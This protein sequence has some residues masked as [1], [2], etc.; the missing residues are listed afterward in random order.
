[1]MPNIC[2]LVFAHI[3]HIG[4]TFGTPT[5]S[6]NNFMVIVE[7]WS[8]ITNK[9]RDFRKSKLALNGGFELN[10]I[11]LSGTILEGK[12]TTHISRWPVYFIKS[13]KLIWSV[14]MVLTWKR[15]LKKRGW[16]FTYILLQKVLNYTFSWI[17]QKSLGLHR[18]P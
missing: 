15:F 3:C 18:T 11:L 7:P 6:H 9:P 10:K 14:F 16:Q 17:R 4:Q 5:W 12:Q 1:M 8:V 2:L 13:W